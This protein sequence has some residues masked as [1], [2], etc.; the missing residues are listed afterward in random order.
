MLVAAERG[1]PGANYILNGRDHRVAGLAR[2][3]EQVT[4]VRA[5]RITAPIRALRLGV[6]VVEAI[7]RVL[8]KEP[9]YTRESLAVLD[10]GKR[11]SH[12]RA[13]RELGYAPRPTLDT[14]RDIYAWFEQAG[15][16][17]R[18]R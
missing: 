6:P 15:M 11:F 1:Q 18:K 8:R 3:A 10:T 13:E 9:L 4:G 7:G 16:L 5:P 12:A 17:R 14:V 2:L